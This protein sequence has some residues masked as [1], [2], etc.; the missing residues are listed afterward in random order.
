M[1]PHDVDVFEVDYISWPGIV[2]LQ[3]FLKHLKL[4][5]E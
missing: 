4:T 3:P 5:R 1:P 2:L